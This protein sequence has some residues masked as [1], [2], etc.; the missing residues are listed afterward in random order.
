MKGRAFLVL[1]ISIF[2]MSAVYGTICMSPDGPTILE[3]D[4]VLTIEIYSDD[5][6]AY[7]GY[8]ILE[9]GSVGQLYNFTDGPGDPIIYGT[10]AGWGDGYEIIP[11][12]NQ[13]PGL[14]C[15]VDYSSSVAG[16]AVV[17]LWLDPD[18]D[19]PVDTLSI[20]VVPEPM[21]IALL[22]LG[23]LFLRRRK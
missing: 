12:S 15:T 11:D 4:E 14:Q 23:G 10:E 7:L 21:T 13:Q 17:S 16:D 6:S 1:L 9:E 8:I 22:S 2:L 5:Y 3:I 18:Y 19:D 20:T